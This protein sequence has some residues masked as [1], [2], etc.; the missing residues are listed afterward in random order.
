MYDTRSSDRLDDAKEGS[1]IATGVGSKYSPTKLIVTMGAVSIAVILVTYAVL[2]SLNANR[3][4]QAAKTTQTA[5]PMIGRQAPKFTLQALVGSGK[6]QL[7]SMQ[8]RPLIL[9]FFAS[10]CGPCKAELPFF[11]STARTTTSGVTFLGIDENDSIGSAR[12]LVAKDHV[13]YKLAF[14]P[15]GSL[16]GPYDLYGFPTTMAVA[17]DGRVVAEVAGQISQSQLDQLVRDA[18]AGKQI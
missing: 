18:K 13:G 16:S 11:A 14:D 12:L 4:S 9:N 17:A 3:A 2:V 15:G 6:V 7:A 1:G 5:A 10:W 8:G